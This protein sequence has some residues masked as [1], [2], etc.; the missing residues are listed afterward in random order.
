M[1]TK[2]QEDSQLTDAKAKAIRAAQFE[3]F[4]DNYPVGGTVLKSLYFAGG[5]INA[6]L[7][8]PTD[9]IV[10]LAQKL[11]GST[12]P[13]ET[14]K[15]IASAAG[16]YVDKVME[17]GDQRLANRDPIGDKAHMAAQQY[18]KFKNASSLDQSVQLGA[19]TGAAMAGIIDP[20]HGGA[21][22]AKV[23]TAIDGASDVSH[24]VYTTE[25]VN[26]ALAAATAAKTAKEQIQH[27]YTDALKRDNVF[28]EA[29]DRADNTHM[30]M[31]LG[32]TIAERKHFED[33]NRDQVG[34]R[35]EFYSELLQERPDIA[36]AMQKQDPSMQGI[37]QLITSNE[38]D[39]LIGIA[40]YQGYKEAGVTRGYSAEK[41]QAEAWGIEWKESKGL[42]NELKGG[43]LALNKPYFEAKKS[44]EAAEKLNQELHVDA[45]LR[46][47]DPNRPMD[48]KLEGKVVQLLDIKLDGAALTAE[49]RQ[50]L[51]PELRNLPVT[52]IVKL[53][54]QVVHLVPENLRLSTAHQQSALPYTVASTGSVSQVES[55]ATR[56][57]ASVVTTNA[58]QMQQLKND[59]I[60]SLATVT[61]KPDHAPVATVVPLSPTQVAAK[62]EYDSM[63]NSPDDSKLKKAGLLI[64]DTF[65]S[66]MGVGYM[67]GPLSLKTLQK[68]ASGSDYDAFKTFVKNGAHTG[69]KT[70]TVASGGVLAATTLGVPGAMVLGSGYIG[71]QLA[72][73]VIKHYDLGDKITDMASPILDPMKNAAL[74]LNQKIDMASQQIKSLVVPDA[75]NQAE[76]QQAAQNYLK[77]MAEL[78]KTPD[79]RHLTAQG[80]A[81]LAKVSETIESSAS[82]VHDIE[83]QR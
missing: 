61:Q 83:P 53:Q 55:A 80:Q 77:V 58:Q 17:P 82:V 11:M 49:G 66:D 8:K 56:D 34:K 42:L 54:E 63:I 60:H 38:N 12:D 6:G 59:F 40:E 4:D 52:E 72:K 47:L 76:V 14:A 43:D 20:T 79:G 32:I 57:L 68:D 27:A 5:A 7:I 28:K 64:A 51:P 71:V 65:S 33:W 67:K 37:K 36:L 15:K 18:A 62:A 9:E 29:L 81:V 26:E 16:A 41:N 19:M 23:L 24:V 31:N 78:P 21:K 48:S 30:D 73:N 74:S 22:V 50:A 3:Q 13:L 44:V 75:M 70:L 69:V 2:N 10:E 35:A 46:L 25:M 45:T 39:H 1:A